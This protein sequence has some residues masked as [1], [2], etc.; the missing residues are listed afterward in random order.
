MYLLT[1]LEYYIKQRVL[2]C[3]SPLLFLTKGHKPMYKRIKRR[4]KKLIK[5]KEQDQEEGK[6]NIS[7]TFLKTIKT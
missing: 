1:Y 2:P 6:Y 7:E 5:Q 4:Y 3:E